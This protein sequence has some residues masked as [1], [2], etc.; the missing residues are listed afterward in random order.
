MIR[1]RAHARQRWTTQ[2]SVKGLPASP[3]TG[4]GMAEHVAQATRALDAADQPD[5]IWGHVSARDPEG[6]VDEGIQVRLR[7]NRDRSCF[8]I[9][10]HGE[11]LAGTGRRHVDYPIHAET[12]ALD[13]RST[14]SC[15]LILPQAT[16]AFTSLDVP[17]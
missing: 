14:G 7:R 13:R 10:W 16:D 15:T 12:S 2:V 8:L 9:G 4:L 5:L 6:P 17:L 1:P 11:V 3:K